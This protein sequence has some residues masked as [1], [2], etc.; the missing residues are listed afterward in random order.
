MADICNKYLYK[1]M[2]PMEKASGTSSNKSRIGKKRPI[3][4]NSIVTNSLPKKTHSKNETIIS[5]HLHLRE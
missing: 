1:E 4:T 3:Q 2:T 5:V